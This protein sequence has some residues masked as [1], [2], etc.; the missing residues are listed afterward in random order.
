M[1][2]IKTNV[3]ENSKDVKAPQIKQMNGNFQILPSIN[4]VWFAD[5]NMSDP[6]IEDICTTFDVVINIFTGTSAQQ[7]LMATKL[8]TSIS[9]TNEADFNAVYGMIMLTIKNM[10][11]DLVVKGMNNGIREVNLDEEESV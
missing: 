4:I 6:F 8:N 11:S 2:L 9:I 10:I 1:S 7:G 3:R 5:R